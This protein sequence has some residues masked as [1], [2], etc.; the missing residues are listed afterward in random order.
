MTLE[1]EVVRNASGSIEGTNMKNIYRTA[2]GN[3]D[4]EELV[5]FIPSRLR[6]I[7]EESL[8]SAEE[9]GEP[10]ME[11][12]GPPAADVSPTTLK[13]HFWVENFVALMP[14]IGLGLLPLKDLCQFARSM[15]GS[16]EET[17][18]LDFCFRSMR[19]WEIERFYFLYRSPTS[20]EIKPKDALGGMMYTHEE[21]QKFALWCIYCKGAK[22]PILDSKGWLCRNMKDEVF[23][24][25]LCYLVE[26]DNDESVV[27]QALESR[28]GRERTN[29]SAEIPN[30]PLNS[31]KNILHIAAERNRIRTIRALLDSGK[32]DNVDRPCSA[33]GSGTTALHLAVKNDCL[34]ATRMLL[35]AGA[36][37]NGG[38]RVLYSP[39]YYATVVRRSAC[40][41]LLL[42]RGAQANVPILGGRFGSSSFSLVDRTMY[43]SRLTDSQPANAASQAECAAKNRGHSLSLSRFAKVLSRCIFG[44]SKE[45]VY[46]FVS[47]TEFRSFIEE[48]MLRLDREDVDNPDLSDTDRNVPL[49]LRSLVDHGALPYSVLVAENLLSGTPFDPKQVQL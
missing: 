38:H 46:H 25:D 8:A 23:L 43:H 6:R 11:V 17:R 31:G 10:L 32:I 16:S 45:D 28:L 29:L 33:L 12:V 15:E 36:D 40:M 1:A 18:C 14:V 49:T 7:T 41:P 3:G 20:K 30:S 21:G 27:V 22:H 34:E 37:V 2:D 39:A 24:A 26:N 35:D 47:E 4:C 42:E 19:I 48:Q 9:S 44:R 5:S 13:R